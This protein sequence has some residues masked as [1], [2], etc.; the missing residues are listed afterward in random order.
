MSGFSHAPVLLE[1]CLRGLNIR[2]EGIYLDGT[3]G[4]AGHSTEIVKRLDTGRLICVDRDDAALTA[5]AERLAPWKDKVTFVRSN[6]D[7]VPEILDDWI[8]GTRPAEGEESFLRSST[9]LFHLLSLTS[10]VIYWRPRVVTIGIRFSYLL[11]TR[12]LLRRR[13]QQVCNRIRSGEGCPAVTG[14]KIPET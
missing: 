8:S 12:L 6:I 1:E 3:V 7:R 9:E 4:G 11:G 5:A 13:R 10:T 14:R 2:P